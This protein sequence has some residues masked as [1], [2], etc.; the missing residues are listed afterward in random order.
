[1]NN[2]QCVLFICMKSNRLFFDI[3]IAK[4]KKEIKGIKILTANSYLE[5]SEILKANNG[6]IDLVCLEGDC[7]DKALLF[8]DMINE[9]KT[10]KSASNVIA[11]S[12]NE[13]NKKFCLY[14]GVDKFVNTKDLAEAIIS[15]LKSKSTCK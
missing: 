6:I 14:Q 11:F 5:C 8:H 3:D 13:L 1:M 2:S 9:I 12:E 4:I 10:F 15:F 7:A